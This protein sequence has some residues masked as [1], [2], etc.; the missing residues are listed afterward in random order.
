MDIFKQA[1]QFDADFYDF[2]TG[3]TYHI[4][5]YNHAKRL[6]LPTDGIRVSCDGEYI[7]IVLEPEE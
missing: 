7:G 4:Q 3:Y 6:G 1:K 2:N 5:E